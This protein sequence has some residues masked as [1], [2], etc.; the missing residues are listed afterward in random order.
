MSLRTRTWDRFINTVGGKFGSPIEG[1]DLERVQFAANQAALEL[2]EFYKYLSRWLVVGEPRTVERNEIQSTEDSFYVYGAGTTVVNGLYARDGSSSGNPAYSTTDES[3]STKY[4]MYSDGAG[5]YI[6]TSLGSTIVG[7]FLYFTTSQTP[8]GGD[9]I[10]LGAPLGG[11]EPA[12]VVV[13]VGEIG[14]L[15]HV[16]RYNIYQDRSSIPIQ[17]YAEGDR[18]RINDTQAPDIAYCTYQKPLTDE[19]GDGQEGT[20]SDIPE[21]FFNY[22]VLYAV[23]DL[24]ISARQSNPNSLAPITTD[25]QLQSAFDS[26]GMR[27]EVQ[28]TIENVSKRIST[29]LQYNSQLT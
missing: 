28:G 7:G 10:A 13:D 8:D 15:L 25:R 23:R 26:V 21:E 2:H 20:V 24:Q 17:F 9:W 18:Y 11:D 27:A 19:Y 22:M 16:D 29:H 3:T 14:I 4:W 1:R 5:W 6:G 12:P